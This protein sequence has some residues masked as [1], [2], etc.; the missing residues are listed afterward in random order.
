MEPDYASPFDG[1]GHD[2]HTASIATGNHGIP[3]VVAGR[4]LENASE[5]ASHSHKAIYK[6][7]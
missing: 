1:D 5:M 3:V 2:T 4:H 6:G 7:I